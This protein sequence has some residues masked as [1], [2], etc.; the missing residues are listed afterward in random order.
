MGSDQCIKTAVLKGWRQLLIY[1]LP[2]VT[3]RCEH[4]IA[5]KSNFP[6]YKPI[7]SD[8]ISCLAVAETLAGKFLH[9]V[10]ESLHKQSRGCDGERWS[11]SASY[12]KPG[13]SCSF[14]SGYLK[15]LLTSDSIL[16]VIS[17]LGWFL[18]MCSLF[19]ALLEKS[20]LLSKSLLLEPRLV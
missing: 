19:E 6:G 9:S 3:L 7:S 8:F 20:H 11:F 15:F 18:E 16:G 14:L 4:L 13:L 10:T 2:L 12:C 5:P 1:Y 17:L